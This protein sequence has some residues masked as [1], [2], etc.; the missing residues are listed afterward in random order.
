MK[1]VLTHNNFTFNGSHY[2]KVFGTSMGTK[3][4]PSI[5]LVYSWV[6]RNVFSLHVWRSLSSGSD[7]L[8]IFSFFG[9][10]ILPWSRWTSELCWILQQ[11]PP[12]HQIHLRIL[13][14]G[15]IYISWCDAVMVFIRNSKLHTDLLQ[16]YWFS[17]VSTLEL[18]HPKHTKSSL[19]YSLAFRLN[20]ICSFPEN[21]QNRIAELEGFLRSRGY[22]ISV[23]KSQIS[24]GLE[25]P[26]PVA[27][28]P[29]TAE[30]DTPDRVPLVLTMYISPLTTQAFQHTSEAPSH[31]ALFWQM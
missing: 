19:P 18:C 20:R 1:I 4:A 31:L 27:L 11:I 14:Q 6:A 8:M 10:I 16:T 23:I 24:K 28:E 26:R 22:P 21:L 25:I 30:V 13:T 29:R 17:S 5:W 15:K 3:M 9:P 12:H 2:R 7:T